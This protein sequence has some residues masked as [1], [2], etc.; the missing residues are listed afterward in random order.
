MKIDT[1]LIGKLATKEFNN[2]TPASQIDNNPAIF[3]TEKGVVISDNEAVHYVFENQENEFILDLIDKNNSLRANAKIK[4][5]VKAEKVSVEIQDYFQNFNKKACSLN[6][7]KE[8]Y[9]LLIGSL[10]SISFDT[11]EMEIGI[12]W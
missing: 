1:Y 3:I 6:R 9:K 11:K 4:D 8:N 5:L 10:N 2:L 7:I 12:P